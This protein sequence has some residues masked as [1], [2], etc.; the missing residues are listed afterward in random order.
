MRKKDDTQ[1]IKEIIN[2]LVIVPVDAS[3]GEFERFSLEIHWSQE[4][5]GSF[6]LKYKLKEG[7]GLDYSGPIHPRV[8]CEGR[9]VCTWCGRTLHNDD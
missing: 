5:G 1:T 9:Y 2:D 3:L 8:V 7:G 4:E 6:V